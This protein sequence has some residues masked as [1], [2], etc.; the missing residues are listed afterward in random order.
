MLLLRCIDVLF[1]PFPLLSEAVGAGLW[2]CHKCRA[3][4]RQVCCKHRQGGSLPGAADCCGLKGHGCH[5]A[6]LASTKSLATVGD[7]PV[8]EGTTVLPWQLLQALVHEDRGLSRFG[9]LSPVSSFPPTM[10]P[11]SHLQAANVTNL[12]CKGRWDYCW[13]NTKRSF[14]KETLFI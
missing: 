9:P 1:M 4:K 2:Y 5:S 14:L 12:F 13:R 6:C 7:A 10:T 8:A 11:A 3:A